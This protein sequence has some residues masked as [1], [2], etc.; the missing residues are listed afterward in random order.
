M[1]TV[2]REREILCAKTRIHDEIGRV[3]LQTRQFLSAGQGNAAEIREAW[4]QN[5]RLLMGGV[6]CPR[7]QRGR[8]PE[9]CSA[10]NR[11]ND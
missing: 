4:R 7:I 8:S 2:T 9:P 1:Q 5:I 10:G 3:L 11:R 6:R